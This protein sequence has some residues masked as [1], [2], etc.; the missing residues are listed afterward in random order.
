MLYLC[1]VERIRAGLGMRNWFGVR[2][3]MPINSH[4]IS[5]PSL[6]RQDDLL[7]RSADFLGIGL[8]IKMP[9]VFHRSE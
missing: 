3:D 7:L 1:H 8:I 4:L 9:T 5:Q 2:V 6:I